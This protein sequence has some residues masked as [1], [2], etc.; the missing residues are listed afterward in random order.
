MSKAKHLYILQDT[1]RQ[2]A[3]LGL[4]MRW[5]IDVDPWWEL[6]HLAFLRARE[7]GAGAEFYT[8]VI[9]A[10]WERG[11]DVCTPEAIERL[12]RECGL[13]PGEL[14]GAPADQ[15]IRAAGVECLYRAYE[16]DIFGIPYFRVGR[17]RFWGLDRVD[18]FL[19]ELARDHV[20][21]GAARPSALA[22]TQAETQA[23]TPGE[24]YDTDTAGGC[25]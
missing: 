24:A 23:E 20:P 8:A 11:E 21:A 19:A 9:G 22:E 13:P 5:P 25:G 6:P 7:L 14:V 2:A 10:R 4:A 3:R 12:A 1:K 16:D 18:A 17:H 15:R